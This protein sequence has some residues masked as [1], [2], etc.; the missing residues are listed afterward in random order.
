MIDNI[1]TKVRNSYPS[2]ILWE[3]RNG[4]WKDR[5]V[6]LGYRVIVNG[7]DFYL[8]WGKDGLGKLRGKKRTIIPLYCELAAVQGG[9][10]ETILGAMAEV[11]NRLLPEYKRKKSYYRYSAFGKNELEAA[12]QKLIDT[13]SMVLPHPI[14]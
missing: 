5:S 11:I 14:R 2:A 1:K 4:R 10:I 6:L 8:F 3:P 7:S 9:E 12:G 13:L